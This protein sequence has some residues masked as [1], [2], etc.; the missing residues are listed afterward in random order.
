MSPSSQLGPVDP[1]IIIQEAE[2]RR[3]FSA[4]SIVASYTELFDGAVNTQG[5]IEPYVQQLDKYDARAIQAYKH[6]IELSK[7]MSVKTLKAGMMRAMSEKTIETRIQP[8]LDPQRTLSHGRPIFRDD[9][10][11]C[12]LRVIDAETSKA[13]CG[14]TSTNCT[15]EQTILCRAA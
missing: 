9:A 12:G 10:R 4:H 7:E 1:Q 3:H 13:R 5:H 15:C 2:G 11:K 14:T 8:F 6:L